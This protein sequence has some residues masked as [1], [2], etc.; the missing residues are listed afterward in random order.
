MSIK[1]VRK[2]EISENGLFVWKML[3]KRLGVKDLFNYSS[4]FMSQNIE[5]FQMAF[6]FVKGKILIRRKSITLHNH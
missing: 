3:H 2:S 5:I 6:F 1:G 4:D